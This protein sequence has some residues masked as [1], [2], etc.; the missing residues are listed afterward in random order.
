MG[1]SRGASGPS[2]P[3]PC[4][5]SGRLTQSAAVMPVGPRSRAGVAEPRHFVVRASE[6]RLASASLRARSM[7]PGMLATLRW[8]RRALNARWAV[9][10][11]SAVVGCV[12]G[13]VGAGNVRRCGRTA[14]SRRARTR[15][16][17]L[18]PFATVCHSPSRVLISA[19]QLGNAPPACDLVAC[20]ES[21]LGAAA[22]PHPRRR[23]GVAAPPRSSRICAVARPCFAPRV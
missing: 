23:C 2:P 13:A 18:R 14:P 16:A 11:L 7:P 12:G 20:S 5:T 21:A 22:H 8:L 6:W 3:R 9:C 17:A 15:A 10:D 1:G 19:R 4:P